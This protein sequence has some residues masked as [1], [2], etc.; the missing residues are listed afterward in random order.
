MLSPLYGCGLVRAGRS[1]VARRDIPA[2]QAIFG[3]N[4]A[5]TGHPDFDRQ[6]R[7]KTKD[8]ATSCALL[9]PALIAEHLTGQIPA[10]SLAG[11]DLLAWQ[12]GK[13]SDPSRIE[14]LRAA[15]LV[16]VATLIGHKPRCLSLVMPPGTVLDETKA[17][18]AQRMHASGESASTIADCSRREPRN[19]IPSFGRTDC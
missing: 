11:Q 10:W 18:L 15:G 13:I 2:G 4:A 19:G 8:L 9:G 14:A 17:A 16:R 12:E 3:E 7:V 1:P 5:A 6:F